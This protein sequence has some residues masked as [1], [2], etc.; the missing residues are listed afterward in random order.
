MK[1]KL[2]T[3]P[4]VRWLRRMARRAGLTA[5]FRRLFTS[6]DYELRFHDAIK[7]AI[8]EGDTAWDV[9]AN[10]GHYAC[11]FSDW[12]G[13]N[14]KVFAFEPSA[15]NASVLRH[16]SAARP[17]IRVLE[18][19][20][21]REP[22]TWSLVQGADTEG[23]TTRLIPADATAPG[24]AIQVTS[25]DALVFVDELPPPQIMKIDTEGF[26]AE[27]VEGMLR[28]LSTNPPRFI[29]IEVHFAI[30]EQRGEE[31]APARI[32]SVLLGAGYSLEWC[33]ASHLLAFREEH[34]VSR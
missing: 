34:A 1:S 5:L 28:L 8:H 3:D 9:G 13:D 22:S 19:A 23:A 7:Q 16:A 14:G 27:V 32:E 26:E 30:L 4:R 17:N 31:G 20:L 29:G 33:D 12:V 6:A 21:G 18:L 25:V 15:E 24:N 10:R 2:I 11:K